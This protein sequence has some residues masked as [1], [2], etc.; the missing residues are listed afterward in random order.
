MKNRAV[1]TERDNRKVYGIC[2]LLAVLVFVAFGES[3]HNE[4]INFD[5]N[6]YVYD[7]PVVSKG[8]SIE[9]IRWAFTHFVSANWHPLT[10]ISHMVDCQFYG[11]KHGEAP[12]RWG[13]GGHHF[14]NVALHALAA[15]FLFLALLEMT[16][17]PWRCG[18]AA[19]L[20]AIHPLRV[21]SVA[22]VSERKD[23]LSGVFFMLTL[24][25]YARYAKQPGSKKYYA[26]ALACFALGLMSKPMLVTTPFVLLLLDY[27]PLGR[28]QQKSLV[29]RLLLE[30]I[31]FLAL[32]LAS[33]VVT[34]IAQK[35]AEKS[36]AQVPFALRL[37][38]SLVAYCEY[39]WKMA[40]PVGLA[41]LYPLSKN[42]PPLWEVAGAA[43][44]LASLTL[45]AIAA[46]RKQPFIITGWLWY[47]GMLVPVIGILQVGEQAYADRYTYLPQIGL[48]IAGTWAV[49]DWTRKWHY[50]REI[51][52]TGAAAALLLMLVG[53]W[54][55]TSQW[56]NSITLWTYTIDHTKDNP[57]AHNNLGMALVLNGM[58]QAALTQFSEAARLNPDYADAH[59]NLGNLFRSRGTASNNRADFDRAIAEYEKAIHDA[60]GMAE[61][62]N[63]LG[64]VLI[65]EGRFSEAIE[66]CNKALQINP[67]IAEPHYNFGMALLHEG[68]TRNGL[69]ELQKALDLQPTNLTILRTLAWCLATMEQTSM[70]NGAEAVKLA[71]QANQITGG[72][73][74]FVLR[75][76][77]AA[78][79]ET[80]DFSKAAETARAALRIAAADSNSELCFL[81]DREIKRYES[82]N[83]F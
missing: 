31:P 52:L 15:F 61:P 3:F 29:A 74:P 39:L 67:K 41:V 80:G 60:P 24:W 33:C 44:I 8:I 47:L 81:L 58:M 34:V 6:E 62:Y 68:K 23:V 79:A 42:G 69:D 27:W 57:V 2:I 12:W 75:T 77:A 55:Q 13:P 35:V 72:N 1:K 22:W 4:F 70:R 26:I 5:D 56:R 28:F 54:H 18:F 14:T 30:K 76:L 20:F 46:R 16:G 63:N 38:N 45:W 53:A 50:R 73:D 59:N 9:G 11:L 25:A 19:A 21:E 7:N 37:E 10:L 83:R 17:E 51:L 43:L 36:I 49:A 82:G 78:Q 32:S 64:G 66:Q 71:M 40:C 48:A 65:L